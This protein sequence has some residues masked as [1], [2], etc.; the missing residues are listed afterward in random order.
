MAFVFFDIETSGLKHDD[1]VLSYA[2]AYDD[3]GDDDCGGDGDGW[4]CARAL[5]VDAES[6]VDLLR[7]MH[8]AFAGETGHTLVTYNAETFKGG[9]DLPFLRT[10]YAKA[11][12]KWPFKGYKVLDLYPLVARY[13]NSTTKRIK[14]DKEVLKR[15]DRLDFVYA[16]LGGPMDALKAA[17]ITGQEV[18]EKLYPAYRD[19]GDKGA[20]Q[21]VATHNLDDCV[22]LA[23]VLDKI[24][25][26]TPSKKLMGE[27][28]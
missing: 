3:D 1:I 2:W 9:F 28:L 8:K 13:F 26:Y 11:G 22:Q 21:L 20:M 14:A 27:S 7:M 10:R 17:E 19:C 4:G 5:G 6:E 15:D 18:A 23:Y 16:I 12:I 25:D 24:L